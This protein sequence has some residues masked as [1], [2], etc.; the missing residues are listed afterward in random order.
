LPDY[1]DKFKDRVAL[2]TG[3]ASGIGLETARLFVEN[4]ANVI[5]ADLDEESLRKAESDLGKRFAGKVCDVSNDE[6]VRALA[7]YIENERDRLDVIVNNAGVGRL[8]TV[9]QMT[10]EDFCFHYDVNVKGPM[11]MVS[12]CLNCLRKSDYASIVN[13]SSSAAR[14]VLGGL[15]YLYSSSK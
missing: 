7:D 3:A 1:R 8:A 11:L 12:R 2:V 15:H 10:E 5:E 4:G 6:D 14:A 13:V 9:D